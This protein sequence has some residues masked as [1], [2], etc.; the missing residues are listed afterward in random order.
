[1]YVTYQLP[2]SVWAD[3][4]DGTITANIT[5]GSGNATESTSKILTQ[6]DGEK[7][8]TVRIGTSF[9]TPSA[10]S[11]SAL[12]VGNTFTANITVGSSNTVECTFKILTVPGAGKPGTVQIGNGVIGAIS[13]TIEGT[14]VIPETVEDQDGNTYKVTAIGHE[15]FYQRTNI[16]G[17]LIIPDSVTQ[18]GNNAFYGCRNITGS[19][20][21]PNSATNIGQT[22]FYGCSGITG[23]L[24]IPASMGF[25]G[26][27]AFDGCNLDYVILL[28][29]NAPSLGGTNSFAG[30]YKIYYPRNGVGYDTNDWNKYASRLTPDREPMPA[31]A[32]TATGYDTGILSG[33]DIGMKYRIYKNEYDSGV[34]SDITFNADISLTG[35]SACDIRVV[36]KSESGDP[37]IKDSD[38]QTIQVRR[39]ATPSVSKTD[40][41]TL[42]NNDGKL[43]GVTSAMEYKFSTDLDWT[44]GTGSDITGLINGTYHVRVKVNGTTLASATKNITIAAYGGEQ[45]AQPTAIFI[46]TGP[47]TGTLSGVT[48]GMKYKIDSGEWIDITSSTDLSLTGLSTCTI[49]VI[50]KGNGTTTIDSEEQ[51]I[52]VIKAATPSVAKADCATFANNDGKLIGVTSAMEY[53]R[54]TDSDWIACAG[55]DITGL[56]NGTY[57]VRVKASGTTLAS[58]P[59]S[60][61]IESYIGIKEEE[62]NATFN[63]TSENGGTLS[64]VTT[65]MKY[66]VDGGENWQSISDTTINITSV[67]VENGVKVYK[68]GNETTTLDSDVQTIM[69]IKAETPSVAKADCTTLANNDG[70]LIGVTSAMEYKRSTDSDWIACAGGDITGLVNGTYYVRVKASGTTLASDSQSIT[71]EPFLGRKEEK[72]N[73]TFTATSENGGTLSNVTTTMKY[74]VDGGETWQG[75]SDT[76]INITGVTAENGVK[77]Y[78]PGNGTT[79]TDSDVQT[80][81]VNKAATPTVSK[82]DCTTLANNDGKLIGVTSA[83]EYKRS[84]DSDW[85]DG[86][87]SDI[88]DLVNGTYLVR[89]KANGTT[90][91]S[92]PQIITIVAYGATQE[93]QPTATFIATGPDTGT[94]SGVTSGM[95]YKIDDGEWK[96]NSSDNDISL[97]DL[98][99]CVIKIVRKGNGTTTIDSD[100][101]II[102]VTKAAT[103]NLTATQPSTIGGKGSIPMTIAH[104]YSCDGGITWE[105]ASGSTTVS[106][107]TY[108]VRAKANGTTLASDPQIITIVAYGATQETQPTATFIATG[109][110]TGT[111]SGVTSGMKY[112]IDGGEWIDIDGNTLN[113]TELTACT[114]KIVRKGNGT[115]TIDSE[116]QTITVSKAA[117][118]TV[119]KADC[120]TLANNDGKLIGVT[121][122]MEYK[123]STDSGWTDG[124]GSDI[125]GLANGTYHVRVKAN[126]T[127]LASAP[128]SITI[129]PYSAPSSGGGSGSGGSGNSGGSGSSGGGS[130]GGSGSSGGGSRNNQSPSA[131]IAEIKNGGSVPK[132][133]LDQL[134][135]NSKPLTVKADNGAKLVFDTDSLKGING[136]ASGDIKVEIKDVS[137]EHQENLPGK[138]VFS[139]TVSSGGSTVSNFGGAVTVSLPYELQE[140]E[141]VQ[142]VTVW[143]LTN[144]GTRTEIPCTYDPLTKLATFKVTHFSLYVVGVNN[145]ALW[146]NPF[147]DVAESDWFY[148]AVEFAHRNGLFAGT[149][150]NTFSPNSPM[151][152]AM[153]WTVLARLDGQALSGSN[154]FDAAR[155]WAM[156][157]GITD[158][159]NPKNSITREQM[160]TILWKYAGSPKSSGD[161]SKFSDTDSVASYAEDA[162]AWALEH[163][164]IAGSNGALMPKG[165]ATRA[166]VAAILQKFIKEAAKK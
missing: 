130:S 88:T 149:G 29:N 53:K 145:V 57:H 100:E 127:T 67:T 20:T 42:A 139:L 68:P 70:K 82:A 140:G 11:L 35:L 37:I 47:D 132:S 147:T 2:V 156:S 89:A 102:T 15:A 126:G 138:Q 54:S 108:L 25:I 31:A 106:A 133:S 137:T 74:S 9:L 21:I 117:T 98:S 39:A 66:S 38:E 104:E 43:I 61:T 92:D 99:S 135:S 84:T 158:G 154:V 13:K 152:R 87:D 51:T 91:A 59:Q 41:T 28:R 6:S 142:D 157:A 148:G 56:A 19:L 123:R 155:N 162:M 146:V 125:T 95:K 110:D 122:A 46:A 76:T 18:I 96:E 136:Q 119:S 45:E 93:T 86:T 109:P 58:D 81:T 124:T 17:P 16:T 3:T 12:S 79:T 23:P 52:T 166:Q 159:T 161:L 49:S 75:I 27:G 160:I 129:A 143:H 34:W 26:S 163:G 32:F 116:E 1:M 7:P 114:I 112:R 115:T 141:R 77:V 72:P 60:I 40:C 97:T 55:G 128:Q 69:V 63:A 134:I 105:A 151:T 73:A 64:N 50:K 4:D 10:I 80:I 44:D 120:T 165:N 153:L 30:D 24:T 90:L 85:T 65:A 33:V 36:K 78:K 5:E 71:I 131:P 103:P 48:N 121:S 62:P 113:L 83:M 111:L 8:E 107:G 164:I 101:Q 14:I 118:P 150:S 22:A 94:L 144:D